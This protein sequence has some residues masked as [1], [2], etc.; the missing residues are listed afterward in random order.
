MEGWDVPAGDATLEVGEAA[1]AD[2]VT[3]ME[4][5]CVEGAEEV[6]DGVDSDC[7]G[8]ID[9]GC[10]GAP[11][12]GLAVAVSW[13]G[14]A[15]VDVVVEG[16]GEVERADARG[17]CGEPAS[18][19]ER[20]HVAA[21]GPGEVVVSLRAAEA[22]GSEAPITASVSIAFEGRPVGVFNRALSPG[23]TAEVVRLSLDAR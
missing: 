15:D 14:D 13:S 8:P 1:P 12:G 9:E 17:A 21:P 4:P 6:C 2:G 11:R 3:R 19:L 5:V 18:R 7:D 22:C 16:A 20:A 23:A 10:E